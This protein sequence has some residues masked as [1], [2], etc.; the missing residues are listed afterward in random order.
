MS[1]SGAGGLLIAFLRIVPK[2]WL[3]R[4]A[5]R[6]A[7]L[8]L[9]RPLRAPLLGLFG[10]AVGVDF[11]EVRDPLDSFPSLQA[12]FVRTLREGVR[13]IDPDPG[14]FVAPCDGAWGQSGRVEQ[15]RLVQV[16]GREYALADLLR[17]ADL[18]R[19]FE[20]GHFATL[21]LSPRDY[22]RFHS[23]C[24]LR[25]VAAR[26]IPGALWPVN[27]A[28]LE[29]VDGLFAVNERI[30][31]E[32]IVGGSEAGAT[33]EPDLCIVAVGATMVGKVRLAFD[34]L[35]TNQPGQGMT[36]HSYGPG[37]VVLEKGQAL[38]HFEFGST[39]VVVAAPGVVEL[40]PR[41]LGTP[42]RL[43]EGI[44]RVRVPAPLGG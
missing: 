30:S 25:V 3:S 40:D 26:C 27:R 41:P 28:G 11:S 5:G 42:L 4:V 33:G 19:R 22:H 24:D 13:P 34:T 7:G 10:R 20:G 17:D 2:S 12:F 44:G 32:T 39:L 6:L 31:C 1:S 21:Y 37:E 14:V 29:G 18:C 23:P 36:R 8:P 35:T 15:G 38:G 43:G 16:K 9:P